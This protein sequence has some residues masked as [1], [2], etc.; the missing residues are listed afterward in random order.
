MIVIENHISKL[1]IVNT[2]KRC[3]NV[4]IIE[5]HVALFKKL[6]KYN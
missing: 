6:K 3:C 1:K 5:N 2:R 4:R